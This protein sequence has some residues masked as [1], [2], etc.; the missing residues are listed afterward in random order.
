MRNRTDKTLCPRGMYIF[1]E[2]DTESKQANTNNWIILWV[3]ANRKKKVG[4]V[5][6]DKG[7]WRG[8]WWFLNR[9]IWEG[10]SWSQTQKTWGGASQ[11]FL[12]SAGG[13]FQT[14]S[15]DPMYSIVTI[16]NNI[17]LYARNLLSVL[18]THTH[19][20]GWLGEVMEM[21]ISLIVVIIAQIKHISN[22]EV[23]HV[24]CVHF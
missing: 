9:V 21:L 16:G 2:E 4:Q 24:K 10:K 19:T 5:K 11:V 22:H 17:I 14:S 18:I 20:Q 15:G 6:V 7:C 12:K 23:V 8:A 1:Q 3:S 13:I